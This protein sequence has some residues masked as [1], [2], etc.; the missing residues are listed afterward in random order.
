MMSA[1]WGS[2]NAMDFNKP[3]V[4]IYYDVLLATGMRNDGAPLAVNYN[5]R[6]L[7]DGIDAM[8]KKTDM[9]MNTGNVMRM[10]PWNPTQPFGTFDLNILVDYGEDG[11]GIPLDWEIPHPNAFWVADSH[12]GYDY[13]L[14]RA[15]EF[16]HVFVS[17]TPSIAK[18]IRDG[19]P[20][21][22]IHYMP[23]AAETACYKPYP[24]IERW[25]WC[26]IGHL[27]N[28]FRIDLV[29]RFCKEWP[30]GEKGY[31]GSRIPQIR[32][33]NVL[34]DVAK[35]FSQ[36]RIIINESVLDD[37]N[38]RTFEALACKRFLLT[39][40]VPDL[41]KHFQDGV[42]LRTFKTVDEAVDLARYYLEHEDERNA[43]AEAGYKEFLSK[44]TYMHRTQEILKVCLGYE[45]EDK[46]KG[47]LLTC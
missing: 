22:K 46:T 35:K 43:I 19:I 47:V 25:D 8:S 23:W 5:L 4:A 24:I 2:L 39:E 26:F 37:L 40:A 3:R 42:H 45:A 1:L 12:V 7:L 29:D 14:K 44:H 20:A 32:G 33:H 9:Q 34:D 30:V 21:E 11:L 28:E 15:R 17:H 6:K 41:F 27:N 13:R 18:F 16:D 31:F 10:S 36:S 38:M